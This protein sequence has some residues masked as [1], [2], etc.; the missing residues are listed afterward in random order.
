MKLR[1][2]RNDF[3]NSAVEIESPGRPDLFLA[4][5][6]LRLGLERRIWVANESIVKIAFYDDTYMLDIFQ[7]NATLYSNIP[8]RDSNGNIIKEALLARYLLFNQYQMFRFFKCSFYSS[9]R[10]TK[11]AFVYFNKSI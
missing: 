8:R 2:V 11:M 4:D 9:F 10:F 6:E 1:Y 5:L 3:V 7:P